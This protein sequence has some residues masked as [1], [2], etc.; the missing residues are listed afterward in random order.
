M[1]STGEVMGIDRDFGRAFYKAESAAN[2][3]L[4]TNGN[5][6]L[7]V[8]RGEDKS[9]FLPIAKGFVELGFKLFSTE[10][11]YKFL[12]RHSIDSEF[13]P[14]IKDEPKI[15]NMIKNN[16]LS[17][18]INIP[19]GTKTGGDGYKIRRNAVELNIPY[20]TTVAGSV[21]SLKAI[22][23][24]VNGKISINSLDGYYSDGDN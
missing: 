9:L 16:E 20:I 24:L 18:V 11:T 10:G 14:K 4:P 2:M 23:S 21:A 15:L 17:L 19:K 12:K 8:G 22:K 3:T 5:I 13:I 1:K 6:L 7:T